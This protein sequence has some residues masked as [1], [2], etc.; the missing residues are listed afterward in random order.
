[1]SYDALNDTHTEWK[2]HIAFNVLRSHPKYSEEA[3]ETGSTSGV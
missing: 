3:S 2:N 1:M